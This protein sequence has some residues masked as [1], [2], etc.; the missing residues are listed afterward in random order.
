MPT[1]WVQFAKD[2]TLTTGLLGAVYLFL[3]RII[4]PKGTLDEMKALMQT[5]IDDLKKD[6]DADI[7]KL[8]RE[9][10]AATATMRESIQAFDKA[11]DLIRQRPP[12]P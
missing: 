12:T 4:I 1:D 7:A 6:R 8:E 3:Q 10:D 5:I 2:L 11:M 9:R